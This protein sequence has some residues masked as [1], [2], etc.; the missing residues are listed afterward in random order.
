M[1]CKFTAFQ[2]FCQIIHTISVVLL[3][4]QQKFLKGHSFPTL[5]F[6]GIHQSPSPSR[7]HWR[8]AVNSHTMQRMRKKRGT[9]RENTVS[10]RANRALRIHNA[11]RGVM[12]SSIT[13]ENRMARLRTAERAESV[14]R[15]EKGA[16]LRTVRP[17]RENPVGLSWV[18]S[19]VFISLTWCYEGLTMISLQSYA[20]T[21]SDCD[22]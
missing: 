11:W 5:P 14:C 15:R 12:C 16:K 17:V 1:N 10:R 3:T 6:L 20:Q 8:S 22:R 4:I 18:E 19:V 9:Q 21:M 7:L 13:C 2:P